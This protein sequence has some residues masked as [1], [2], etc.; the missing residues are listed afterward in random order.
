V[1]TAV[2]VT[3]LSALAALPSLPL[4]AKD[5]P[6][7]EANAAARDLGS[8]VQSEPSPQTGVTLPAMIGQM[9]MIGFPG[10]STSE[11]WPRRAARM[12]QDGRVGGVVLFS[13][14]VTDPAQLKRLIA[15]LQSGK[16][17]APFISVDQEGGTIQRLT[18]AK[19]FLGLPSAHRVAKLDQIH[20]Y[21]LYRRSAGELA[22]L[23][24]NVSFG[25][26]VDLNINA[27]NP[28]IGR[29][30]RS[31]DSD[32]QRVIAFARQF[33]DAHNQAG[34]LTSA[35]HFP[36]H[37]SAG[38]DPHDRPVDI[39][40]TWRSAELEPFRDLIGDEFVDMIMV[41]HLVH[42]LFSDGD[43]PA[44]LS[45]RAI[46]GV[47]RG[48]LGFRGLVVTDDLDMG[49]I[50]RRY[51]LEEAAVAAVAAGADLLVI[52]NNRHPDTKI[53][54]RITAAISRAIADN[55]IPRRTVENA[56]ARI[57]AAKK[58][59]QQHRSYLIGGAPSP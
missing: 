45:H 9:I 18:A 12:I 43:R 1:R 32:P 57:A 52:A 46:Q 37:G 6:A 4:W 59:L 31:Y 50:T 48:E 36:G 2:A 44:S 11:E 30:G 39:S 15:F 14:N 5:A 19:G 8:A 7:V 17:P 22:R 3:L 10:H 41:S 40:R 54:E 38:G 49:A 58:K 42:P 33:I 34:V 21:R 55:R 16:S 24:I 23:G 29:L 27:A 28:A 26:V 51:P 20:A 56:Y 13:G 47:L 53:A 35:K 25:P